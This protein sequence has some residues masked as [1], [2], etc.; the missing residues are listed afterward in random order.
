M[1]VKI[2]ITDDQEAIKKVLGGHPIFGIIK[3]FAGKNRIAEETSI[4]YECKFYASSGLQGLI[5]GTFIVPKELAQR[6]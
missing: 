6:V 1:C 3:S 4:G 2:R 5:E